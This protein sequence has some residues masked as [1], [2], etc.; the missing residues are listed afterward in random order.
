MSQLRVLETLQIDKS[1]TNT[2][3]LLAWSTSLTCCTLSTLHYVIDYLR[4]KLLSEHSCLRLFLCLYS[5][6]SPCIKTAS[7]VL[8]SL[9]MPTSST[10]E[11]TQ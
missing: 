5:T 1:H 9:F 7:E 10:P 4:V 2:N 8:D 3:S 11:W 6:F